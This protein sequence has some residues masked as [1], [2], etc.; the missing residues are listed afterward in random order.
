MLNAVNLP[1][2]VPKKIQLFINMT[3][4]QETI[5]NPETLN[6]TDRIFL[7]APSGKHYFDKKSSGGSVKFDGQATPRTWHVFEKNLET[8]TYSPKQEIPN[9]IDFLC[10]E[11]MSKKTTWY[12]YQ[13]TLYAENSHLTNS[14]EFPEIGQN[15]IQEIIEIIVSQV[16]VSVELPG[17]HIVTAEIKVEDLPIELIKQFY[18]EDPRKAQLEQYTREIIE[19]VQKRGNQ[20][21]HYQALIANGAT[22]E[23]QKATKA[24]QGWGLTSGDGPYD[25]YESG[26]DKYLF[27]GVNTNPE[28]HYKGDR[29]REVDGGDAVWMRI[30]SPQTVCPIERSF[31]DEFDKMIRRYKDRAMII[32]NNALAKKAYGTI[33]EQ[34]NKQNIEQLQQEIKE[35]TWKHFPKAAVLRDGVPNAA[36]FFLSIEVP[37]EVAEDTQAFTN[38]Y[39]KETYLRPGAKLQRWSTSKQIQEQ[40]KTW[41]W[42]NYRQKYF[43]NHDLTDAIKWLIKHHPNFGPAEDRIGNILEENILREK[44]EE[45]YKL[46]EP[47]TPDI[48]TEDWETWENIPDIQQLPREYD[49]RTQ[50]PVSWNYYALVTKKVYG[51]IYL[52]WTAYTSENEATSAHAETKTL[53]GLLA[54]W[55]RRQKKYK[56]ITDP[57]QIDPEF[58]PKIG[59]DDSLEEKRTEIEAANARLE[60]A[61]QEKLA[62]QEAARKRQQEQKEQE[63]ARILEQQMNVDTAPTEA[64]ETDIAPDISEEETQ[65]EQTPQV[66]F[67]LAGGRDVRCSCG[68][69]IRISK[70]EKRTI[71]AG[72]EIVLSCSSC[73]GEGTLSGTKDHEQKPKQTLDLGR[74][75]GKWGKR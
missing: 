38:T 43:S 39:S 53:F 41:L 35:Q 32:R 46:S 44:I 52:E 74:L 33:S 40:Y 18:P 65:Q 45:T 49:T 61:I 37:E 54:T 67:S 30:Q 15:N 5:S 3:N 11:E 23:T 28:V 57:C 10:S 6:P 17:N 26:T 13:G 20:Y 2:H 73:K 8:K 14:I 1:I 75:K 50:N 70:G 64:S 16:S 29:I 48:S 60:Q 21:E 66:E 19:Q 59:S 25:S 34:E 4:R 7:V 56:E 62:E 58:L 27:V 31:L 55:E 69:V 12:F 22:V 42:E 47:E 63:E 72:G 68:T 71:N 24:W 9:I 51:G 36:A